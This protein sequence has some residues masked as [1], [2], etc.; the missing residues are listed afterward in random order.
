M[1]VRKKRPRPSGYE[2]EG[3]LCGPAERKSR[4]KPRAKDA[5][6][7]WVRPDASRQRME[8]E[9]AAAKPR[10]LATKAQAGQEA[11]AAAAKQRL[12]ASAPA[13]L[14][15][16]AEKDVERAVNGT[17]AAKE[18]QQSD[19][20]Q[21]SWEPPSG[22]VL[23]D[24]AELEQ[25]RRRDRL[26]PICAERAEHWSDEAM[27]AQTGFASVATFKSHLAL[28]NTYFPQGIAP[29]YR[30][31]ESVAPQIEAAVR[32]KVE[33]ASGNAPASKLDWYNAA[34]DEDEWR[35]HPQPRSDSR[36][37]GGRARSTGRGRGRTAH[38]AQKPPAQ[39]PAKASGGSKASN[40]SKPPTN[41]KAKAA[42]RADE[43]LETLW[44]IL[45]GALPSIDED[46]PYV[47]EEEA[48]DRV[49]A[50]GSVFGPEDRDEL[51][52][53]VAQLRKRRLLLPGLPGEPIGLAVDEDDSESRS[54]EDSESEGSDDEVVIVSVKEA[55]RS[56][57]RTDPGLTGWERSYLYSSDIDD[58]RL[59]CDAFADVVDR[60]RMDFGAL[61]DLPSWDVTLFADRR[62]MYRNGTT[63]PTKDFRAAELTRPKYRT[64]KRSDGFGGAARTM[65][66]FV[67]YEDGPLVASLKEYARRKSGQQDWK[68]ELSE[69]TT[70]D[71]LA[72][73]HNRATRTDGS[74]TIDV[75][76]EQQ[77]RGFF[78]LN[79]GGNHWIAVLV[80]GAARYIGFFDS[81]HPGEDG[82]PDVLHSTLTSA[83]ARTPGDWTVG[84][85]LGF[86]PCGIAKLQNDTGENAPYQCGVWC[87]T[88]EECWLE[89]LR[90]DAQSRGPF[91][92]WMREWL[93]RK[94]VR[95]GARSSSRF[96]H[97][98]REKYRE[99]LLLRADYQDQGTSNARSNAVHSKAPIA[100]ARPRRA[101]TS[102][103]DYSKINIKDLRVQCT[104][105]GL[106]SKGKKS[107]LIGRLE[108]ADEENEEL[109]AKLA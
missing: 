70:L 45:L 68:L 11:A 103:T 107:A 98:Q 47:R 37:K 38:R 102:P 72:L 16:Q 39:S 87:L 64:V 41:A 14:R 17:L 20:S 57:T 91:G 27:R 26:P 82:C 7:E 92:P 23:V 53:L 22:K 63:L 43:R 69:G 36:G 24:R 21:D 89:F 49:I 88:A 62:S 6:E 66:E 42:G 46:P 79:S 44:Y 28:F 75:L 18:M 30:G 1:R 100:K 109:R 84:Y 99:L 74:R 80:D 2:A 71:Y 48:F 94:G 4:K 101:T 105:R 52:G 15:R 106:E 9:I 29:L 35:Y 13:R 25:L 81:L 3:F 58:V 108:Q 73:Y 31:I 59:V 85:D 78:H 10:A 93:R 8:N 76:L 50:A 67:G 34:A 95:E 97:S 60:S 104:R 54:G 32:A 55:D 12:V 90:R 83:L 33:K 40:R 86:A 65:R 56:R 61:E 96:I 51:P 5:A 19:E 77:G